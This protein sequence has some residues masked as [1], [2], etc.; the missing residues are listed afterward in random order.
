MFARKFGS[1]IAAAAIAL[2]TFACA[3]T[4]PGITTAVKGKLAA[5]DT[6]KAYRIDVDTK[7]RVVTLNGAVDTARAR[8]RAIEL[9]K[10]TDGVTEV[11]DRLT[12]TPGATPTT[13]VDDKVQG[14]ATDTPR[15]ADDKTDRAQ[16]KA[17][18]AARDADKKTDR[19]QNKAGDTSDRA[20]DAIGNAALTSAIKTK[21]LA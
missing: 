2:S 9:A 21:F 1:L 14:A 3:E 8:A 20:G 4:D 5:D 10:A 6:V 13:G 15:A 18:E 17:G 16:S 19:A 11:V 7:N 12:V